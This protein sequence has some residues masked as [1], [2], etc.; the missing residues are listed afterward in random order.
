MVYVTNILSILIA[1][2]LP[3][4]AFFYFA[5]KMNGSGKAFMLGV[6]TF[7]VF[8]VFT[9]IPLLSFLETQAFFVALPIGAP[10]LYALILSASAG[11]FEEGGRFIAMKLFMKKRNGFSQGV[12]FGLGH[13]GIEAILFFGLNAVV[14]LLGGYLGTGQVSAI[15]MFYSGFER[16]SAMMLHVGCSL[17]VLY[18]VRIKNYLY[19]LFAFLAHTIVNFAV[20]SSQFYGASLFITESIAFVFGALMI[21]FAFILLKKFKELDKIENDKAQNNMENMSSNNSTSNIN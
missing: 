17:L 18:S 12:A 14:L 1:L 15:D 9:R 21:Y 19:L 16:I 3:V 5:K 20:V 2:V 11:L 7:L 6:W 10:L 13:G 8:Q 4:F